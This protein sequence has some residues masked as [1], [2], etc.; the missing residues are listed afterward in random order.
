VPE[1]HSGETCRRHLEGTKFS[2]IPDEAIH[3]IIH[4]DWKRFSPEHL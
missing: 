1:S 4:E 3:N 2:R